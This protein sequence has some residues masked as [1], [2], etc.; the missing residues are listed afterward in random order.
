MIR[1]PF[2]ALG[3]SVLFLLAT[4]PLLA[5]DITFEDRVRAQEAIERVTYVH[6]IGATQTFEQAYPRARLEEK[7]RRYLKLSAALK[8]F[9]NAP[10]TSDLL[11]GEL[12]RLAARTR[13]PDRLSEIYG[14]LGN[15]PRT[16]AE[17]YARPLLV[18]RLAREFLASD[19]QLQAAARDEA[20]RLWSDLDSGVIDPGAAHPRRTV[21]LVRRSDDADGRA[22]AAPGTTIGRGQKNV[23]PTP[24][25]DTLVLDE[26]EYGRSRAAWPALPGRPTNLEELDDSY[27]VRVVI[28]ETGDSVTLATYSVPKR[29]WGS[30]WNGVSA[31]LDDTAVRPVARE[32]ALPRPT[33][34]STCGAGSWLPTSTGGGLSGRISHASVWTGNSMI[35]W[36]GFSGLYENTGSRYDPVTDLWNPVSTVNAPTGRARHTAIWAGNRMIVWGGDH[37][38]PYENTGGVYDPSTDSWT[39]TSLLN[40][41]DARTLHTAVWTGS[42]ML[43]FGGSGY[44]FGSQVAKVGGRYDPVTDTWTVMTAVGAPHR[45][46]WHTAVWTGS[47]MIIWGG[48]DLD[49]SG[50]TATG[51]RYDPVADTWSPVTMTGVPSARAQHSAIWTGAAMI[52][53]GGGPGPAPPGT[54]SGGRYDPFTDTWLP[55]ALSGAPAGRY[56]HSAVW[57]GSR[58]VVWGGRQTTETPLDTG[59][60]YD[61]AADSWQPTSRAAAPAPRDLHTAIWTGNRMIV[62]GGQNSAYQASGGAYLPD[63]PTPDVDDDGDGFAACSGD[64][65][66]TRADVHP[67]AIELCDDRDNDCDGLV[68][69]FATTCGVGVCAASGQCVAGTDSCASGTA[70]AEVCDA[71]D[72]DCDGLTDENLPCVAMRIDLMGTT[73]SWSPVAGATLYDLVWGSMSLLQESGGDY[74]FSTTGCA[75]ADIAST[76]IEFTPT[77]DLGEVFWLVARPQNGAGVGTYDDV[78]GGAGQTGRRDE[79]I[80]LSPAACP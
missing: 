50:D 32:S 10:V 28:A 30:W 26:E 24:E 8:A 41:P 64:C 78:P 59:G 19:P 13:M 53:W 45:R 79:G 21:S 58:M 67:G 46:Y 63:V 3:F 42:R 54:N 68:D 29:S 47:R 49:S 34:A 9:W 38:A 20:T 31:R 76:Q 74:S 1:R 35:V 36:G 51:G 48:N 60:V 77:P 62:W 17:C 27:V 11:E 56:R 40:A 73:V 16:I 57:T 22:T 72:N 70:S 12:S 80:A 39:A 23:A 69:G 33:A 52:V 44:P 4:A 75:G 6:Q 7:V 55:T 66:D 65:D 2:L 18:E 15:D 14:A 25:S 61:P 37:G 71:L 43:V 5:R